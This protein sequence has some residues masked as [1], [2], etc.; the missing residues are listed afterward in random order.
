LQFNRVDALSVVGLVVATATVVVD[1][2]LLVDLVVVR[3]LTGLS[4][5]FIGSSCVRYVVCSYPVLSYTFGNT[6]TYDICV[7]MYVGDIHS[8]P[9]TAPAAF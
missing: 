1:L 4:V 5:V 7:Y 3:S 8:N 9:F 6:L 2:L